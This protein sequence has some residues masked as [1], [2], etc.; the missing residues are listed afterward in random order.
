MKRDPS[1]PAPRRAVRT[2]KAKI[3]DVVVACR[4]CAK[5]Q[6]LPKR[7]LRDRL[8]A[9]LKRSH[10]GG[11]LRI[12]ETGCLGPCPKH[13]LAVA[14]GASLA[15]GRILLIDPAA[16][17]AEMLAALRPDLAAEGGPPRSSGSRD[18]RDT[19]A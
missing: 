11:R 8:K 15:R 17:P 12:V 3:C 19:T 2:A 10:P 18:G 7:A 14:T 5:R 13:L 6:G 1:D 4:K 9:A 16:A